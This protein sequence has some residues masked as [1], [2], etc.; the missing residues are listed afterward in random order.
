[1]PSSKQRNEYYCR[2]VNNHCHHFISN[3]CTKE[4]S[5]MEQLPSKSIHIR[6][7]GKIVQGAQRRINYP[8]TR[9]FR[10]LTLELYVF[11]AYG[12]ERW[13]IAYMARAILIA[14]SGWSKRETR[15]E[16]GT[17]SSHSAQSTHQAPTPHSYQQDSRNPANNP[18]ENIQ[19][20]MQLVSVIQRNANLSLCPRQK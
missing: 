10:N 6:R 13:S 4:R 1:M 11:T 19:R 5:K 16:K 14:Y 17:Q 7:I 12:S 15:F 8:C 18:N 3:T 2:Q 9:S 20:G